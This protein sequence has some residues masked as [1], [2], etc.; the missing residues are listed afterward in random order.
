MSQRSSKGLILIENKK[1]IKGLILD[2]HL[3]FFTP[4]LFNVPSLDPFYY[5]FLKFQYKAGKHALTKFDFSC[6]AANEGI[7]L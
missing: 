1:I 7:S 2:L 5:K 3:I 6:D 4:Y